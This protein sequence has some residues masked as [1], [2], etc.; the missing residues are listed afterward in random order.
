MGTKVKL[1]KV[2]ELIDE[3]GHIYVGGELSPM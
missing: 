1:V 2:I 3:E